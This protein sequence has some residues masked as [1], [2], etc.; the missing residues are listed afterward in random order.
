[1]SLY[2]NKNVYSAHV[3]GLFPQET[4]QVESLN[5]NFDV[6]HCNEVVTQLFVGFVWRCMDSLFQLWNI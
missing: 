1:M 4:K 2:P 5:H 6:R 3:L